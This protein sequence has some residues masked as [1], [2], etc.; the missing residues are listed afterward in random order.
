PHVGT[1]YSPA[2][3]ELLGGA[4]ATDAPLAQRHRD[5][6]S[7]TQA[8]Y[9]EVFFHVL[10]Q[11]HQNHGL[12]SLALAGGCAMNSVA[13]GKVLRQTPYK[14]LYVQA[15]AGDAGGALG[16]AIYTW[17]QLVDPGPRNATDAL[18]RALAGDALAGR[19]IMEHAYLGPAAGKEEI[20]ALL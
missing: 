7:S 2:I 10:N 6:A 20:A 19:T 1:L 4:R 18:P 15:A 3:E 17:H 11:L 9:E 5:L 14:R 8:V 13:N 12:D 16:A